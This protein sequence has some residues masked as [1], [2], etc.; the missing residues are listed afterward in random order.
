MWFNITNYHILTEEE[1]KFKFELTEGTPYLTL[2][3]KLWHV[4]VRI[5]EKINQ[6]IMAM[7]CS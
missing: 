1:Y 6:A 2:M 5:L 3:G 7:H 4:F